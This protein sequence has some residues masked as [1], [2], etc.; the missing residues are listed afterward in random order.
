MIAIFSFT[1]KFDYLVSF[2][3]NLLRC[4][5]CLG[6]GENCSV[7]RVS[8]NS[9]KQIVCGSAEDRCILVYSRDEN[10]EQF[11]MNCSHRDICKESVESCHEDMKTK[12]L[13]C[14]DV[15]CCDSDFCN[16]PKYSGLSFDRITVILPQ[17]TIYQT[18]RVRRLS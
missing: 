1:C 4:Y 17:V 9:D 7:D 6:S 3:G 2:A 5:E 10:L 16:K 18:D 13:E 15:T 8:T 12:K 11:T 14:C